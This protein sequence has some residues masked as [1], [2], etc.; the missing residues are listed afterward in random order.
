[1]LA[2]LVG[3]IEEA[4]QAGEAVEVDLDEI[5]DAIGRQAILAAEGTSWFSL[6]LRACQWS[7]VSPSGK[8]KG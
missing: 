8:L 1:V 6:E 7:G 4:E 5:I 3:G 2:G